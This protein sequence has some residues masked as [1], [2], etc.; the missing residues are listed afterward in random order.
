MINYCKVCYLSL[1]EEGQD[2]C[3]ECKDYVKLED[4]VDKGLYKIWSRNLSIGVFCKE[5][6]GFTG[7]R[8]KWGDRFLFEEFHWDTGQPYG[9]VRPKNLIEIC[10]IE[11]IKENNSDLFNYLEEKSFKM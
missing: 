4:C 10:P 6:K 8:S 11:L 3:Y 2:A 9:T 5:T 7:V 1:A